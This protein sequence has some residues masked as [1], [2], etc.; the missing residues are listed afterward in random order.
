MLSP[1]EGRIIVNGRRISNSFSFWFFRAVLALQE[2][3][4]EP[5]TRGSKCA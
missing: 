5:M 2:R 4:T 1:R 3:Q